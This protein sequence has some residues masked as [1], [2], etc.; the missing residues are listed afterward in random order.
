MLEI[1]IVECNIIEG[2]VE[3]FARAWNESGQIGFGSD[4]TVDIERF[5]IYN[6]PVLVED[7]LGLVIR[8]QQADEN[9]GTLNYL[10]RFRENPEEAILQSLEQTLGVMGN[11]H[12]SASI[13]PGKRGNTT[14]TFYPAAGSVSP[15]DGQANRGTANGSWQSYRDGAGLSTFDSLTTAPI[16]YLRTAA[17]VT[18][19]NLMVRSYFL[20]NTSSIPDTDAV[21]SATLS[22]YIESIS[23]ATNHGTLS[24]A[25]TVVTVGSD[26]ALATG[27]YAVA[28]FGTRIATDVP[29]TSYT[30]S[31]YYDNTITSLSSINKTG[32]TRVG[33]LTSAEKDNA[34]PTLSVGST[35]IITTYTADQA[36]TSQDPKLVVEHAAPISFIPRTSFV[37]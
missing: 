2:G 29:F 12:N 14:S 22:F 11:K 9:L 17:G 31:V 30:A 23:G 4:G 6:P 1:E 32:L 36:G 3:V 16:G 21:S 26:S 15:V 7:P 34:A 28:N 13:V 37:I 10:K 18:D 8:Q 20:F 27:D 35:A 5:L 25:M 33:V 19:V 24:T